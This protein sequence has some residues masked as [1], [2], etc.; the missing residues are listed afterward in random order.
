MARSKAPRKR[1]PGKHSKYT[2]PDMTLYQ[3]PKRWL[4]SLPP[5]FDEEEPVELFYD[6]PEEAIHYCVRFGPQFF[7]DTRPAVPEVHII[8]GFEQYPGQAAEEDYLCI[9]GAMIECMPADAF[10]ISCNIGLLSVSFD[11]WDKHTDN[12]AD[13]PEEYED[14]FLSHGVFPGHDQDK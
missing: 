5:E 9:D 8:R 13:R 10:V 1:K 11:P 12:W 14:V 7:L 6:T 4:I 3:Y 2:S